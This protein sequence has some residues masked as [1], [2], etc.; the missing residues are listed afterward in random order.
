MKSNARRFE[1]AGLI[2]ASAL[3][4]AGLSLV[5]GARRDSLRETDA[6]L[7]SGQVVNLSRL[8]RAE[9]L[10][11]LLEP[12]VADRV[13]RELV[14]ET[15]A[16]WV[17]SPERPG[18]PRRVISGVASLGAITITERDLPPRRRL[19]S[20]RERFAER[21]EQLAASPGESDIPIPLLAAAQVSAIRRVAVVRTPAEFREALAWW[22]AAVLL[23]FYA[24]HAWLR[25]R[26]SAG[27]QWL[28][29]IA[30]ALSGAGLVMMVSLR[31]PVRDP[32]L[33]VRFAQGVAAGCVVLAAA[34]SLDLE[35]WLGRRL[36]SLS[37]AAAVC[38]S[39]MLILFGS[40]PG[41]SDAK[42]NLMGAQPV[43][44]IRV[45]VMI[46]LAGHFAARW[47]A[48]R[49]A[50]RHVLLPVVIGMTLVLLFFFLQKDL[51]PA[52]VL[53]CVFLG[54][55]VVARGR[56][57]AAGFGLL[58]LV[59]GFAAGY[60]VRYPHTVA[61]RMQMWLSPWD[62][63]ARGGDQVAHALWALGTGA[64]SGTGI[65]LGDPRL[66]PAGHTDLVLA[67]LGE[68][69]GMVGLLVV[70]ALFVL[71]AY[72]AFRIARRA[73]GDTTF[74]LALGLTIGIF[75][76]LV[77][78]SAGVL[79]ML[80]LA[81]ITT[82]F[83][84]YGRSSM[85]ANF[86]A[87]GVLLAIGRAAGLGPARPEFTRQTGWIRLAIAAGLLVVGGRIVW[88]QAVG[89]DR[90]V[91]A[92]AIAMQADGV[93]R[94][95]Y[96][97]RLLAVAQQIVRGTVSDR[98][99]VPLAT[100]RAA[101]LETHAAK[102]AA[103]G[104]SPAEACPPGVARCYPFGGLTFHLL[105]DWRSQVNWA[106]GNTSFIERDLDT[107]LRGYNDRARVVEITDPDTGQRSKVIRRDLTELVPLL[108][109]RRDPTHPSVRQILDRPRDVR[110]A[111]DIGLQ[112]Q[113][114]A[115]LRD[116]VERA[117]ERQ[118][119]AV[120]LT[121]DGDLLASVSYPWPAV[122]P[123]FVLR[124]GGDT[125]V[126]DADPRL[127]DRARYGVYPPGSSFALV[128]AAAA[129]RE[130]PALARQAFSCVRLPDHRVGRQLPNWPMPVRDD[131]GQ[132]TPH[133]RLDLE[134]GLIESCS[135]YLAQLGLRLGAPALEETAA[136]FDIS[137]SQPESDET[138]RAILPF[139]A[140]GQGQVLA[141]P[142]K[143]AR[144]AAALAAGGAM[145]QGRW[146]ID[147]SNRRTDAPRVVLRPDQAR[148]LAAW[149]RRAVAE[150]TGRSVKDI[151]PP[152][153]GK[154]GSA[155]VQDRAAHAW[156]V[157]FAPYGPGGAH[158]GE[159]PAATTP[160]IAFAVLVEHGEDGGAVAAPIAGDIVTAA[161]GLGILW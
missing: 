67:A 93:R 129:L 143:M 116:G 84:S 131:P 153:A 159:A 160:R 145:P 123:R 50:H 122:L 44:A 80:P 8:D 134:R 83:L 52:L 82:P 110:L 112:R 141:T 137:L 76:Q 75:A 89:A 108:R 136:L 77:L 147:E 13:D 21:H 149:M 41:A 154:T 18:G 45:L 150:G 25:V 28:L 11:P 31:D 100:S 90:F 118:G 56:A 46:F 91:A 140:S 138:V 157:G 151:D 81:G 27:D 16:A 86:F 68:E 111:L 79:G 102:L 32:L 20:F 64:V 4:L 161:K 69:T 98:N 37:L 152:I 155:E 55:Y 42:V 34:S 35:R 115:L 126:D 148:L 14:A 63:A 30:H 85:L 94:F 158:A 65:G 113:V 39:L 38:L 74:F 17:T 54:L 117:G 139:E 107:R 101:D 7:A 40:G 97:P 146:V 22:A 49:Q 23:A 130:D 51:G 96:N 3:T 71:L 72:R 135:A 124:G 95:E 70:L 62:N 133:G 2:A 5:S 156:F 24:A 26:R 36:G 121:P 1:L 92:T 106:A 127:M 125:T 144:V 73:A 15:I 103:L 87:V 105:G 58:A 19:P 59:A 132:K 33:F 88:V 47:T 61:Q 48:L 12:I 120:V 53:A 6:A 66:I 114:A 43:E 78:I 29:P 57:R 128:T 119:A 104:V 99:G 109:H 60:L 10:L 9:P 142:F